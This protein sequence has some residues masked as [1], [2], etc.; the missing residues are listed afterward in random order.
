MSDILSL[1]PETYE[2][3]RER[4]RNDLA[5]IQ[6]YWPQAELSHYKIAGDEDLTIDWIHSSALDKNDKVLLFTTAEHGIEGYV[7]SA[8]LQ[9]FI[10][11]FLQ[12][13]D[14]RTTGLLLVHTINPWGMKYHRRVNPNNVDLNRTFLWDNSFNKSINPNYDKLLDIIRANKPLKHLALSNFEYYLKLIQKVLQMGWSSF[15]SASLLGQYRH[16]DGLFYG[17]EGYQEET[18]VMIGLYRDAFS[19]YDQIL[20]LDIH[21]GYGP[22][23]QMSLVNS[24]HEDRSPKEL[25]DKFNYPLVVAANPQEFYAIQGDMIDFIYEMWQHDFPEKKLFATSFEFGTY[26]DKFKGRVGMQHAMSFENRLYW[27][28]ADNDKLATKVR[29]NFEELFNPAA[30]GWR[31]K[32]MQD[33]DQAFEGILKADGYIPVDD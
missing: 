30:P 32:A 11:K 27:H 8:M 20:H 28:G 1:F 19:R 16:P 4:F 24:V 7:G 22:R 6:K 3:S 15:K 23:F 12:R 17:G 18:K 21:T 26:G 9:R 29:E 33:A 5:V 14:P 31:E 2:T 10:D 25:A 13:L